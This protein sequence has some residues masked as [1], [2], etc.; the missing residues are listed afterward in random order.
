MGLGTLQSHFDGLPIAGS[1]STPR[2]NNGKQRD[3][4]QCDCVSPRNMKQVIEPTLEGLPQRNWKEKLR[5][6]STAISDKGVCP[7]SSQR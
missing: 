7:R 5:Q 2:L 6:A 4:N 3:D 1:P